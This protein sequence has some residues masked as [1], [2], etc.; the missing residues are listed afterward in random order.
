MPDQDTVEKQRERLLEIIQ[1]KGFRRGVFRLTSGRLSAYY[2]DCRK[3]SLDAEGAYL[4]GRL[5][6]KLLDGTGAR[7]IGGL[8]LG[9][10]PVVTAV[11]VASFQAG[12]P[13][14]AF[15]VRKEVKSHGMGQGIEGPELAPGMSVAIVDDVITTGGSALQAVERAEEVGATVVCVLAVVDR[16]EGGRKEM[17]RRGYTV[18][19]LFTIEDLGLSKAE[20]EEF[21]RK[22]AAGEITAP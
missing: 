16:Q 15:I 4:I 3:V 22:V 9:A 2:I 7:A 12:D 13:I 8:T 10:D 14:S 17:E 6:L 18:K 1:E 11:A 19:S 21:D 5:L 20:L